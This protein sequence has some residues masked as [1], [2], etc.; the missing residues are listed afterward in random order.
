MTKFDENRIAEEIVSVLPGGVLRACSAER[1]TIRYA[2]RSNQHKLR[3]ISFRR[4]SLRR[5]AEDPEID[6]DYRDA[7]VAKSPAPPDPWN[8]VTT[9]VF[10]PQCAACSA[11]ARDC[12]TIRVVATHRAGLPTAPWRSSRNAVGL[13]AVR[14][15]SQVRASPITALAR[16]T[17]S[18][19]AGEGAGRSPSRASVAQWISDHR[20]TREARCRRGS[21][22]AAERGGL[23]RVAGRSG[24]RL[25]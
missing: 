21:R 24:I 23:G 4:A 10:S 9:T 14:Q 16:Q 25:R 15:P 6:Q 7:N 13:T 3:T 2:V 22:F 5:L 1:D 18:G 17:Q 11:S 19:S 20:R 8:A 12:G